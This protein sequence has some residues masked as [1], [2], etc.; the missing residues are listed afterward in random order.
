MIKTVKSSECTFFDK[1]NKYRKN[2]TD[3]NRE[4]M[5]RA[6]SI[7]KSSVR[8]FKR[9]CLKK[10]T[11][12]LINTRYKDAKEYWKLLKQ[13]QVSKSS[14]SLSADTF[15]EYFKAIND[16]QSPFYQA[17]EDIIAFNER[18]LN[19]EAQVMFGELDVEITQNEIFKAIK[20]LKTSRSG[21]PDK[22]LNEFFIHGSAS[23]LPYLHTLFNLLFNK[24]YFPTMWSEGYI[25]PIHKKGNTNNVDNYR[26]ITLLS[27]LGK[28]FTSIL[29]NRL[30]N[31][32]ESYY[33]YI[34]AQAGFRREMGTTDNIFVLHGLITHL[35]NQ[36]KKLYCAFVDFKKA[37]DFVNRD[38][39]WYKLIKLG[40]RGK[41]L[42]IIKSMY[43]KVKARVKYN[44][45]LS[46]PFESYLGVRQGECLSPFLFSMYLNDI[47]EDFYLNG[48]SGIDIGSLKLF[49]LLYADD[50][51]IFS[52][53]ED[54]L[55]QGL[56]VLETYC[57]RWKLTVN[58][59]KT[60]VMVFRKGGILRR[61]LKFYYQNHELEIVRS[62]SY[63]GIVFTPGGSFSNAQ[64]TLAGQAQKAIFKLNGYL[65]NF[66]DITPKHILNL[67]D[68]L[69]TPILNYG[70]EVWGFCNA[71]QIERVHLQFCKNLLGVKQSTQ[72]NFVYGDL[73]RMNYQS[74]RYVNI[75]KY[76]LKV[77]SKPNNKLVNILYCQMISDFEAND[78]I[79]NWAVL[80]RKLLCKLGFYEVWLQ[81]GVGNVNIFLCILNNG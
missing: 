81:Q 10:K 38:I 22:L 4:E 5:V 64:V 61:N 23:L 73:G 35:I 32:A 49:L 79:I 6:R 40:V 42:D 53:T 43:A 74:Y 20:E 52:E 9:A 67:F 69:V 1:L 70:S 13:S 46:E 50:M 68:K 41:M 16:P 31:W 51:T 8:K 58:K 56:N 21:G 37:F 66:S 45:E 15:G 77:I 2:K 25:V 71:H 3:I 7:F 11:N 12:K 65:Y 55:Q 29:N 14:K 39:I 36:G 34:E 47:E 19:S 57:N 27:T 54:G 72:N 76:W 62:F 44:N 80:V 33:V 63:L 30:I 24:G 60:K 48:L 75:I 26:G 17:D 18:F 59:D 78:S 28:L